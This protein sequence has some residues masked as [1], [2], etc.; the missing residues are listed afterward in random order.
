[1]TALHFVRRYL[2]LLP[3][4]IGVIW[5]VSLQTPRMI[6]RIAFIGLRR[7]GSRCWR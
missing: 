7:S 2:A 4:T 1:M 5:L 3:V 6:R